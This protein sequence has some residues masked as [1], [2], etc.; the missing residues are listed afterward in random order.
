M[1]GLRRR[2]RRLARWWRERSFVAEAVGAP[3]TLKSGV[4]SLWGRGRR[5][6]RE[7]MQRYAES[8]WVRGW[9][10]SRCGVK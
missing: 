2:E 6:R 8:G 10:V 7:R 4:G 3:Q 9:F 1:S 5:V